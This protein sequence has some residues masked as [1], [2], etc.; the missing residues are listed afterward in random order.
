MDNVVVPRTFEGHDGPR[1]F[2]TNYRRTFGA[3]RCEFRNVFSDGDGHAAMEWT[4]KGTSSGGEV[5][6]DGVSIL[7]TEGDRVRRFMAYFDPRT[8][9]EQVVD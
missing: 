2:W 5:A 1:E 8:L 7:E 3:M 9:T 6:Y 4:T